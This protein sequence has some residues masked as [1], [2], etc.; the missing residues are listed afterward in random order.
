MAT[1]NNMA[2]SKIV[3]HLCNHFYV[4]FPRT[5]RII[6]IF[7]G[8]KIL[9]ACIYIIDVTLTATT[10]VTC[11]QIWENMIACTTA[12]IEIDWQPANLTVIYDP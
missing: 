10:S 12:L 1:A 2:P 6:I 7:M 8:K 5:D 3:S 9:C 4:S 11:W